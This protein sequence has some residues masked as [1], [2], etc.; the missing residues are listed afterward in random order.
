MYVL[1][2]ANG[3]YWGTSAITG[4]P[5]WTWAVQLAKT[6]EDRTHAAIEREQLDWKMTLGVVEV[7]PDPRGSKW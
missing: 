2:L 4:R 6:Y 5:G 7:I 3:Q 1:R